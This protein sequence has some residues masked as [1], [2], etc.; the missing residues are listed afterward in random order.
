VRHAQIVAVLK[1]ARRIKSA[2]TARVI[3]CRFARQDTSGL[4]ILSRGR[5]AG[6]P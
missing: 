3:V 2:D 5:S 6:G 1:P 4:R